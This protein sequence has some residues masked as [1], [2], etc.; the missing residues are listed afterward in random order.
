MD[1]R[2]EYPELQAIRWDMIA[3]ESMWRDISDASWVAAT[4]GEPEPMKPM[5]A[6]ICVRCR[7]V[8]PLLSCGNCKN[9]LFKPGYDSGGVAGLFC[10]SCDRGSTE[11]TCGHCDTV[12]PIRRSLGLREHSSLPSLLGCFLALAILIGGCLA[13]SAWLG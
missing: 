10:T 7:G 11:W 13:Y 8:W 6:K 4:G 12:N 9:H 3:G 1:P 2:T 5:G